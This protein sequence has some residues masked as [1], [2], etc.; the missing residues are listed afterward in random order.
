MTAEVLTELAEAL[1]SEGLLT[2]RD[3]VESYRFDRAT[4]C[5]AGQPLVVVRARGVDQV[6]ATMRIASKHRIP[7]VPQGARS[8]L[9]GAANAIDDCIVLSLEAMN[10]IVEIDVPNRIVVTQPG[11]YNADLSRAV[12]EHGLFYPPDPSSWEFCSIGGNLSTNSGG[13]CCVKYG[14]TTDYVLGL[15]VV[16][17]SGEV[18]RTGRRTV[19]GVAGYDLTKLFVGSEG[20]LGVITEATLMLRPAT[21]QPL[22]VAATYAEARDAAAGVSAVIASGM[23]PSLLEFMDRTSIQAVSRSFKLGFGEEV[24]A[25][26]IAQSDAGEVQ[27]KA[28]IETIAKCLESAG[29]ADLIV[30]EDQAEGELLLAAR[31]QVIPAFEAI[32]AMLMDDVCVPRDRLAQLVEGVERLSS[33]CGLTVGVFGHAGDGN[34]HPG[35]IFDADDPKQRTAAQQVF[36]DIM[37]LGLELG[38]TITGEHGVGVLKRDLLAEEVGELS[39]RIHRD[40]KR[41]LDPHGILNPGKVFAS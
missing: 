17:A 10:E 8:G 5:E 7:V 16:L 38:G 40:I 11:I 33:E 6:S 39:L 2:D 22:T 26:V 15:Q 12:G 41:A 36:A 32:G 34:F 29:A 19:K 28:D 27:G 21:Q 13:L 30:A 25:L 23:V 14:V 37:R 31:R 35:V 9:S 20:T 3:L 18:L 24:G 4:F 1:P